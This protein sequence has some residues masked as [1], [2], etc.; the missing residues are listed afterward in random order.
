MAVQPDPVAEIVVGSPVKLKD[1]GREM[2]V[3]Q[4]MPGN[5]DRYVCGYNEGGRWVVIGAFH[6]ADLVLA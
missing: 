6:A 4:I 3:I 5:P 2:T 1:G